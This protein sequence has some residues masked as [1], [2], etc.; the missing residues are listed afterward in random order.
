[1]TL[2]LE[3]LPTV[4][5]F[6]RRWL[7]FALAIP[8]TL[9]FV[10]LFDASLRAHGIRALGNMLETQVQPADLDHG[11]PVTGF[12][13]LGGNP[14]R[15]DAAIALMKDHPQAKIVLSGPGWEEI[16]PAR[17]AIA[18]D[19]LVIDKRPKDTFENAWYS[20]DLLKPKPGDRW[21]LVTSAIHMPRALAAFRAV[22]FPVEP[23]PVD[24]HPLTHPASARAVEHEVLGLVYYL[25]TGQGE[26]AL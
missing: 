11:A 20:R 5:R 18:P 25:L 6:R 12:I 16:A 1:M 2:A 15:N 26:L 8:L 17:A 3:T 13:V 24:D 21:I 4:R 7:L 19:A 10:F 9:F 14:T 22:K 23:W